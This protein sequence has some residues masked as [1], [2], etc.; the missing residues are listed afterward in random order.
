MYSLREKQLEMLKILKRIDEICKKNNIKYCLAYG[1]ALGAVRHKGFIPWDD[2][3]DIH[4]SVADYKK[5][6]KIWHEKYSDDES[7]FLQNYKT[8]VKYPMSLPKIRNTKIDVKEK[9]FENIGTT[10]GLWVDIFVVGYYSNNRVV[11]RLQN[12]SLTL[13]NFLVHKYFYISKNEYV[14]QHHNHVGLKAFLFRFIPDTIRKPLIKMLFRLSYNSK[15]KGNVKDLPNN[16]TLGENYNENLVYVDFENTKMPIPKNY[17]KYF[18]EFYGDYMT[19]V[20]YQHD[21]IV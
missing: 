10:E 2:D 17:D 5:F 14:K 21:I 15:K 18:R 6:E 9:Y 3:A 1:T 13:G 4:M 12:I 19:P 7:F 8:D 16:L 20:K 11:Q